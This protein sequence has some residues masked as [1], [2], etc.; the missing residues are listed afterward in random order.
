MIPEYK[1]D[2][3]RR[4]KTVKGHVNGVLSMVEGDR[5][6]PDVMAQ[7]A[8]LQASLEKVNRTLLRNH[9]ETCV[10]EAI[11]TGNGKEKIDELLESLRFNTSLTDLRGIG[12]DIPLIGD[13]RGCVHCGGVVE[14]VKAES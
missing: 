3:L 2:I 12:G 1:S 6:C 8:A 10:S 14:D 4:L 13:G 5:Y 9:L 7:V 11:Q